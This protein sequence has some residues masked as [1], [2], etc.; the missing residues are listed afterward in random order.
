VIQLTKMF[1]RLFQVR[2]VPA[3]SIRQ[4]DQPVTSLAKFVFFMYSHWYKNG[5]CMGVRKC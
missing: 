5:I 4:I 2:R 1:L 3:T